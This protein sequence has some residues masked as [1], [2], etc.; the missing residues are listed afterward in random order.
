[1]KKLKT[2]CTIIMAAC[3]LLQTTT[4][5]AAPNRSSDQVDSKV[6][7]MPQAPKAEPDSVATIVSFGDTLCHKGVFKAA[8]DTK[9]K[10]Y[11][12]SP[13]FKYVKGYFENATISI[14]NC[15]VPMAGSKVGYS[16]YPSFNA[17][18]Q[19]ATDLKELGVDIMTTANNHAMDQGY[20]GLEST[21]N[22]L[23]DA[24]I[25]HV[26][27]ARSEEEYDTILIKDL[28]GIKTAFLSYTYGVNGIR[29]PSSKK[30][31]VNFIDKEL[32]QEQIKQAKKE[33][34]E[35]IVAS[36][37]WGTEY[38]TEEN[39][40]QE[41][42]AKFLIQNGVDIILGSHPHVL[43]PIKML[44]VKTSEGKEREGLVIYSQGNF[45]SNQKKENTQ[46]TAIFSIEVKKDGKTG[47]VSINKVTYAPIYVN[48]KEPGTKNRY[49]LLDLNEIIRSYEKGEKTWSKDKY[50][51]ALKEKEKITKILGPEIK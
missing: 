13:M 22:Y 51:L 39:D 42:M 50:K 14:G 7:S 33:G 2:I 19:L 16:G 26:G 35:L 36:M 29:K 30:Y 27:T 37:H 48:I 43:Q 20:R 6:T 45:F 44:K 15:E 9:T 32:I 18:E 17:P 10:E 11:D 34:A 8:Y 4:S 23:D 40:D 46:D 24:G 1:M 47:K 41:E 31:C 49:E 25:E 3:M 38:K 28:N 5:Y 12:F 21:L